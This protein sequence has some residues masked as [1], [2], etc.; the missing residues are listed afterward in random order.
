VQ[1]SRP[2]RWLI[3][4]VS[5][6][7]LFGGASTAL[8]L[9]AHTGSAHRLFTARLAQAFG[10]NVEVSYYDWRWLPSPGVVAHYVTIGEDPR[11]GNEY[12]LR[13][14]SVA[15]SPRWGALFSGR[16]ELGSLVLM[17]PSLN[18]V[19][20]ADGKWNVESWLPSPASSKPTLFGPHAPGPAAQLSRIEIQ[21]GRINF[22][23]GPDR[24]PFALT[25]L[26]G[27]IEQES[28]GRWRIEL[29]A[30]PLRATVHLQDTGLIRVTGFISGTSARLQP[31][32]LDATWSD[33]SLAD[34]ARLAMGSDPG[35]RGTLQMEL[36]AKTEPVAGGA[37][38]GAAKWGFTLGANVIAPHGWNIPASV[39][40]P[41]LSIRA[42][43]SWQAGASEFLL[44][45]LLVEGPHSSIT[46]TGSVDWAKEI[47]PEIKLDSGGVAFAD[48]LDW[49]RAFQPGVADGLTADG[50]LKSN[51]ELRGWPLRIDKA[52]VNSSRSSVRLNGEQV[53]EIVGLEGSANLFNGTVAG[54]IWLSPAPAPSTIPI[55]L[56][57]RNQTNFP[58]QALYVGAA[59]MSLPNTL[60]T[61]VNNGE[62]RYVF[63]VIAALDHFEQLLQSAKAVG[64]SVSTN[65]DA[66]GGLDARLGWVWDDWKPFPKPTGQV[67]LRNIELRLPL[68]NQPIEIADAKI[69]LSPVER[70]ITVKK[71]SA[72]GA[73]WQGT[74]SKREIAAPVPGKPAGKMA[75]T[76]AG[77][78]AFSGWNF[79]LTADHLDAI[80]LD[81]WL[82]PRARPSWLTRL[83]SSEDAS[84]N[85]SAFG[86]AAGQAVHPG[87][88]ATLNARGN[89]K[90]G[91]FHLA[92]LV[93]QELRADVE[94]Q[95]RDVNFSK[96]EAQ[97]CGGSI[98]GGLLMKL[99]ADP[100]YWLE[101]N[102]EDVD[103]SELAALNAELRGKLAGQIS[104]E[105]R[106]SMHGIGKEDLLNSLKGTGTLSAASATIQGFDLSNGMHSEKT[107][108]DGAPTAGGAA[109]IPANPSE[110]FPVVNADFSIASRRINFEKIALLNSEDPFEGRGTVDFGRDI[111]L[112]LWPQ[113]MPENVEEEVKQ[114]KGETPVPTFRVT[115][116]LEAP[117]VTAIAVPR[118]TTQPAPPPARH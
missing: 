11:F 43:A 77:N 69:D 100:S 29:E 106:V 114:T 67:G 70:R 81:Q 110:Q 85:S 103:A 41:S 14:Q 112:D 28:P 15:A 108:P 63:E 4:F 98:T 93:V 3:F 79:D 56:T 22:S 26:E 30:S 101:L 83:F 97:L 109:G 60:D 48:L 34:V 35:L 47:S 96:F 80:Q 117:H 19:R 91:S 36:K 104:G 17:D 57:S 78:P 39:D 116:T 73:H 23:R 24:H 72:L 27:S 76:P 5:A 32:E 61:G 6:S 21:R 49:Y 55:G 2:H 20:N 87:P 94:M 86:G 89:L 1:K 68:L 107:N 37:Q 45:K 52:S 8:S 111:E 95:G 105:A 46:G 13:A 18:L 113:A 16:L 115:G 10:R 54:S 62:W 65:W 118:S 53:F 74:A 82:G 102:A 44:S 59:Y 92:P 84:A 58:H 38:P 51:V 99:E 7:L 90:V 88:L 9:I 64:Q 66:E 42:E 25:D 33:A 31:A 75:S 12:F 40:S 50:Y 71:A